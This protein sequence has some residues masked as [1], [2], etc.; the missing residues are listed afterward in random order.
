MGPTTLC[1]KVKKEDSLQATK[2]PQRS[3]RK[4]AKRIH[5]G[6]IGTG[7]LDDDD[8]SEY[9]VNSARNANESQPNHTDSVQ[10]L[11]APFA[12]SMATISGQSSQILEQQ[13]DEQP[14]LQQQYM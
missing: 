9:R 6:R 10:T 3:S 12:M 11:Q 14:D 8:E 7:L 1:C 4:T 5:S 2:D 13:P